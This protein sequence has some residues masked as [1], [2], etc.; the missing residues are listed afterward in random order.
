MR[1]KYKST[2]F[3]QIGQ[4][5]LVFRRRKGAYSTVVF[6]FREL[7][8]E[9]LL[10]WFWSGLRVNICYWKRE[11]LNYHRSEQTFFVK[12]WIG[13]AWLVF[14]GWWLAIK[15]IQYKCIYCIV[16]YTV[17][18]RHGRFKTSK[19]NFVRLRGAQ[20]W[21]IPSLGF[22]WFLHHKVFMGRWF[23]GKK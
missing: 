15:R 22:S 11:N 12:D 20:A 21:D 17:G 14:L 13:K 23:I 16:K 2:N 7:V 1:V 19:N 6:L 4:S 10:N 3:F 18:I 8:T 9:N 5:I